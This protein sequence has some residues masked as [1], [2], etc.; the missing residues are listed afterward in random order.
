MTVIASS[1]LEHGC[2]LLHPNIWCRLKCRL[3]RRGYHR[4]WN[5]VERG[6]SGGIEGR[7]KVEPFQNE[8][9]SWR[10]M[11][12]RRWPWPKCKG[13]SSPAGG[14]GKG[15]TSGWSS[16]VGSD[17]NY[18]SAKTTAPFSSS[19]GPGHQLHNRHC[20]GVF[21]PHIAS[22]LSHYMFSRSIFPSL[23]RPR[24]KI[25]CQTTLFKG[26]LHLHGQQ[27]SF[28]TLARDL[29]CCAT[30]RCRYNCENISS[31]TWHSIF[32]CTSLKS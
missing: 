8:Q 17:A 21:S 18:V 7:R 3:L 10:N 6:N 23:S 5:Q 28:K 13:C 4:V 32:F 26:R 12:D 2:N 24:I 30:L 1:N 27:S 25:V 29:L 19:P 11:R 31:H 22:H 16:E 15:C 9:N 20:P 14:E